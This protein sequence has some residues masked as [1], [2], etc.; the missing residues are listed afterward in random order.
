MIDECSFYTGHSTVL[1]VLLSLI[2]AVDEMG[3]FL[4]YQRLR[5]LNSIIVE[6]ITSLQSAPLGSAILAHVPGEGFLPLL[7]CVDL[8]LQQ[9]GG[10]LQLKRIEHA[11]RLCNWT[12]AQFPNAGSHVEA[13][14]WGA[15]QYPSTQTCGSNGELTQQY[16]QQSLR[17]SGRGARAAGGEHSSEHW[18][19]L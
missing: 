17:C 11:A 8:L 3:L 9:E 12:K 16:Q 6:V 10:L 7:H 18:G 4:L 15:L 14:R 19:P 2:R 5:A 1:E 13:S